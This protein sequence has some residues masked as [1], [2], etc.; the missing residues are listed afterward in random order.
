MN[1]VVMGPVGSGK[2]T[3]AELLAKEFN[4]LLFSVGDLLYF[5]SKED[6]ATGK[7]IRSVMETG[8]LVDDNLTLKLV[9]EHLGRKENEAGIIID[10][11][12]RTLAQAQ[13][14]SFPIDC[15]IYLKVGDEENKA[16]LLKRK[17]NDDTA[18][19]IDR[20]LALYH[21]ETEPM[22][23]YYRQKGILIEVDGERPVETIFEELKKILG[24]LNG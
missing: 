14:F 19:I 15:V 12:P 10:G 5:T 6:S 2:S 21:K 23:D 20:R 17:R 22:L 8:G 7:K 9:E 4:T 13:N 11:F 16:R 24:E 18:E 3:Q 1:I